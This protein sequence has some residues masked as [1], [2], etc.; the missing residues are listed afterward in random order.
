MLSSYDATDGPN[1]FSVIAAAARWR[2][3]NPQTYKVVLAAIQEAN[4]FI[5]SNPR[6]AAEIFV[7]LEN[8]KL[9]VAFIQKMIAD[10]EFSYDPAPQ[11][12]LKIHGFMNRVGSLRNMPKTVQ[13]LFFAEANTFKGD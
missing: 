10:P 11:N 9:P 7:K 3:S 2:E 4:G 6:E 12:V 5:A 8:T 1:T 13:E